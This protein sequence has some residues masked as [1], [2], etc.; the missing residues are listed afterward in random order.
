MRFVSSSRPVMPKSMSTVRPSGCTIR[1]PPCRSPWK[2]PYNIAPSMND[3]EAGVQHRFGVD[4][5]V[6][7]RGDVV[8]RDAV[9]PFHHEH[10]PR[11]ERRVRAG[12]DQSRAGR[13][14]AST[15][16]MSS[17]FSRLEPEVELLDDRLREQLDE[18]GRVGERGDRDAADE[19]RC[20]PRHRL[21]VLA[22]ELARSAAA[23]P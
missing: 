18:R 17:M 4:A 8:P 22:H 19:P 23:A 5:G 15:R 21:E 6:V 14:R 20:E 3:D 11:H 2:T 12:H 16:A 10:A 7:H 1:L 9:E 13:S